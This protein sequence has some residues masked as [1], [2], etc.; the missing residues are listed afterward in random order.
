MTQQ[1][2]PTCYPCLSLQHFLKRQVAAVLALGGLARH[3][4]HCQQDDHMLPLRFVH[5]CDKHCAHPPAAALRR[6]K[7]EYGWAD[8]PLSIE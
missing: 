7:V 2:L 6:H 4:Y 1:L 5:A 8:R 3:C